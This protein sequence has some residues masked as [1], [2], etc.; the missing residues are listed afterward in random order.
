[1]VAQRA[2]VGGNSVWEGVSVCTPERPETVLGC[3]PSTARGNGQVLGAAPCGRRGLGPISKR[4]ARPKAGSAASG[5][6][7]LSQQ[8]LKCG[9]QNRPSV[10]HHTVYDLRHG[11]VVT[12]Q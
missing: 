4:L 1:M 3:V 9:K 10:P 11:V 6:T 7:G 12:S 5:A 2:Q 8:V